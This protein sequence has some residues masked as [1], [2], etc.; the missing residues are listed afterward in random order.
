[1]QWGSRKENETMLDITE[2]SHKQ[3]AIDALHQLR[4]DL[5]EAYCKLSA[6]TAS[7]AVDLNTL[8]DAQE[9][10]GVE[11]AAILGTVD[12][13]ELGSNEAARDA[14]VR[15]RLGCEYEALN[16]ATKACQWRR[17]DQEKAR[18]DV[19]NLRAQLRCWETIAAL[20]LQEDRPHA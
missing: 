3:C 2:V 5:D 10:L 6:C 8:S 19:D 17:Q 18:L 13:K 7:L 20:H 4:N 16:A 15:L 14:A 11:K 12:P 9:A 1:M